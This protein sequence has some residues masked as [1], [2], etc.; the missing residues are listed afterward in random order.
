RQYCQN[1]HL[2]TFA[3]AGSIKLVFQLC[4]NSLSVLT[5]T[6]LSDSTHKIFL[7]RA[8]PIFSLFSFG[9]F[10]CPSFFFIMGD[11]PMVCKLWLRV[12]SAIS[13][14]KD[15][16]EPSKESSSA[17]CK[18]GVGSTTSSFSELLQIP[19]GK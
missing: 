10:D 12:E 9:Y 2:L 17:M 4:K 1:L 6:S 15:V 13:C 14:L 16:L 8:T 5:G 18:A 7:F 3:S 11:S 19:F